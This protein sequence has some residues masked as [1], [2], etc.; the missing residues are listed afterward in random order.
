MYPSE[1]SF[2]VVLLGSMSIRPAAAAFACTIFLVLSLETDVASLSRLT[3]FIFR[4][5]LPIDVA[6][7]FGPF[8]LDPV[9]VVVRCDVLDV[10]EGFETMEFVSVIWSSYPNSFGWTSSSSSVSGSCVAVFLEL[11]FFCVG[12]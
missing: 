8:F 11:L 5:M 3:P 9:V 1:S 6:L 10:F 12:V 2:A 7:F 4:N